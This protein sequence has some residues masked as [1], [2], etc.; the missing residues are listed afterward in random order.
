MAQ[1][2]E[3]IIFHLSDLFSRE[4]EVQLVNRPV[5]IASIQYPFWSVIQVAHDVVDDI[6][7]GGRGHTSSLSLDLL[8]TGG[9]TTACAGCIILTNLF[10]GFAVQIGSKDANVACLIR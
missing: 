6:P 7:Y 2:A 9:P 5:I 4:W 3:N 10:H 1:P 8:M